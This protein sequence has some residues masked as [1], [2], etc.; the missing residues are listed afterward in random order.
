MYWEKRVGWHLEGDTP[1]A[2]YM[3]ASIT[4]NFVIMYN[5]NVPIKLYYKTHGAKN[6]PVME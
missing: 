1:R 5:Y 3:Y 2:V 4:L 6:W